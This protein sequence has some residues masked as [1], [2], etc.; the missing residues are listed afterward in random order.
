MD[1]QCQDFLSMLESIQSKF[2]LQENKPSMNI[3]FT[4]SPVGFMCHITDEENLY[5]LEFL[6]RHKIKQELDDL[7][8]RLGR[9]IV[10]GNNI[11]A[12][13]TNKQLDE[14]FSGERFSFDIPTNIIGTIFQ[15]AVWESLN[16]I[17]Y[18]KTWSYK[19]Q[20]EHI[21][22]EKA[23]RAVARTNG[24]NRIPIIYPCHRV[25]GSNG[26]LTGYAGGLERKKWLLRHEKQCK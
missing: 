26:S 13:K 4:S 6:D 8:K 18:G 15:C 16:K 2:S 9:Q 22:K 7:F 1:K 23:V 5:L 10:F 20:A 14:Y 25:I 17:P 21:G 3:G 24:L 19:K 11:I 12:E